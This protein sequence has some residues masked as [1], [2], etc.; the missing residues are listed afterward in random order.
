MPLPRAL[1]TSVS[2]LSRQSRFVFTG[3]VEREGS[4]SLALLPGTRM[5][6]VVR[7]ERIHHAAPAL[8]NQTGQEVTIL[9]A[10]GATPVVAHQRS[11][12]FTNPVLYGETLGVREIGHIEA[13]NDLEALHD[14]VARMNEEGRDNE[15]RRHLASADAVVFGRVIGR[16]PADPSA[17]PASEHDPQWHI[18]TIRVIRSLKGD[19]DGE[20]DVRYPSSRD[21][22][23]YRV[24]KP[25]E[26]QEGVF[27]LHRDGQ[28]A[29]DVELA[30][31]DPDDLL[32]VGEEELERL[33]G[34]V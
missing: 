20:I 24:P 9:F 12:F 1:S 26:G 3:T 16:R 7:I 21:I 30:L 14:L 18:A 5:T 19:L 32:P 29:G 17:V 33:G 8:R 31:V 25:E 27:V 2:R 13:P 23:W 10:E 11:V 6:A 15:V 22:R 34:Y 4:S 28:R